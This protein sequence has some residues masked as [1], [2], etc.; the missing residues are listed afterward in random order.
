MQTVAETGRTPGMG[1]NHQRLHQR[2]LPRLLPGQKDHPPPHQHVPHMDPDLL[3]Q[4]ANPIHLHQHV[5]RVRNH[6]H[7]SRVHPFQILPVVETGVAVVIA[8]EA[9]D[10]EAVVAIVE[11]AAVVV[12]GGGAVVA[13]EVEGE[14]RE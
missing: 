1:T 10:V 13:V 12:G 4:T 7:V 3:Y 14:D 2:A 6:Q 5:S 9:V 11:A 8:E